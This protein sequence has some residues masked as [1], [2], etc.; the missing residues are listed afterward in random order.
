MKKMFKVMLL[1]LCAALLVAGSVLGTLAYLQMKTGTVKNTFTV[2]K[3]SIT[4]DEAKTDEYGVTLTGDNA[5]RVTS[6]SYKLVPN[7]IYDKAPVIHVTKGSEACYVFV[8]VENQIAAIE[9]STNTI[10]NQMTANGWLQLAEGS[11]VWYKATAI[12]ARNSAADIDVAV[13]TSFKIADNAEKNA[14]WA[15]LADND[16]ANDPV[17]T[18]TAYAVQADGFADA[19]AAWAASGFATNG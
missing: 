6:N 17:I 12:D 1:V 18:V 13:F 4:L 15:H 5:A 19:Q 11:T 3:V 7:H 9:A 8:K 14:V 2:G 16:A 10:A